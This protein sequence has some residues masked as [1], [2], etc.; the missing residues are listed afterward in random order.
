MKDKI[1]LFLKGMAM[2]GAD[3]VPGVSGGTIA[4]ISG[5]YEELIN[6]IKSFN[7]KNVK[8]LFSK[9]GFVKF[10]KAVNGTFLLVL[11]L[12]IITSVLSVAKGLKFLL[13]T[14]PVLVWS[15]FFGLIIASAILVAKK[16]EKWSVVKVLFTL[17]FTAIAWFITSV[18]PASTPDNYL[19]LFVTGAIAICA[20]I[21]PGI[22]GAFILLLLGK[23]QTV[24]AAIDFKNPK[25][26][27][28]AVIG[29]GAV[30]GLVLFSNILSW[31]L[32][33]FHDITVACLFGFMLGSLNK[34]WPWKNTAEWITG[35]HGEQVPYIQNNVLPGNW[36]AENGESAQVFAAVGCMIAGFILIFAVEYIANKLVK[37]D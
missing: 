27:I 21:L 13:D 22:S 34:V 29:A 14:Y 30:V 35:R 2:G 9:G 11:F 33:K 28:I 15:F 26:D 19:F 23:Y 6:S 7:L 36:I 1:L 37:R 32:R 24:L 12:G 8:L 25:L 20:M 31:L 5:I 16:V 10:W 4:F 18:S 17:G 3:I